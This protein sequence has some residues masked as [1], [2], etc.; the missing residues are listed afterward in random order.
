MGTA[1]IFPRLQATY[2]VHPRQ[3][4]S[5]EIPLT[6][7]TPAFTSREAFLMGQKQA[8]SK[9]FG[10]ATQWLEIAKEKFYEEERPGHPT[11][12]TEILDWLQFSVW[13]FNRNASRALEISRLI[14]ERAPDFSN[15]DHNLNFYASYL[16]NLTAEERAKLDLAPEPEK[17]SEIPD[18]GHYEQLCRGEGTLVC[19]DQFWCEK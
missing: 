2:K 11:R 9:F 3:F 14:K 5:G 18:D 12:Y 13:N 19:M 16:A 8:E 15:V 17:Y 1:E 4:F 10:S 7:H 6:R